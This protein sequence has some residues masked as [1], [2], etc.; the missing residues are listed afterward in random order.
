LKKDNVEQRGIVDALN[1][2]NEYEF[3]K[4][5]LLFRIFYFSL[6]LLSKKSPIPV[7]LETLIKTR[8]SYAPV[9]DALDLWLERKAALQL[10]RIRGVE[11]FLSY[12]P[13]VR[14]LLIFYIAA[15][16]GMPDHERQRLAELMSLIKKGEPRYWNYDDVLEYLTK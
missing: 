14:P 9:P 10:Y 8:P 15:K 1:V 11:P 7:I 5:N 6:L 12:D 16:S 13:N 3:N 2:I 4:F